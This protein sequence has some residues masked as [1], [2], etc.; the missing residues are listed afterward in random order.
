VRSVVEHYLQAH[1]DFDTNTLARLR[2][3][4]W[5]ADWPQSGE[6]IPNHDAD[7]AIHRNYDHYPAHTLR[8]AVESTQSR[9]TTSPFHN[10][11]RATEFGSWV[12]VEMQLD[13]GDEGVWDSVNV[14][15]M[16][17]GLIL[18]ETN[19]F[20]RPFD[21]PS[22]RSQW[23]TLAPPQKWE[24]RVVETGNPFVEEQCRHALIDYYSAGAEGYQDAASRLYHPDVQVVWLQSGELVSGI[25]DLVAIST[26]HPSPPTA[27][28]KR[29]CVVGTW[30]VAEVAL[31]YGGERWFEV[32][33][34]QFR[35][36]KVARAEMYFA[37]TFE[38]PPE[39]RQWTV[40]IP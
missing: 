21:P 22:W 18:R 25:D 5:Y 7:V 17:E 27:A 8:R 19:Y 11:V 15:E 13:Y 3:P 40:P 24:T 20:C 23:V 36:E 29:I 33:L 2:H 4:S 34:M 26:H 32:A 38:P 14:V 9:V 1:T 10:L 31:D 37:Q 30:T 35:D 6:R 12:V 28:V 16:A 39:R